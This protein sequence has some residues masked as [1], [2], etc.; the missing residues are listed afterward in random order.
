MKPPQ[1]DMRQKGLFFNQLSG[2]LNP[3][4]PI[5]MLSSKTHWEEFELKFGASFTD[6]AGRPPKPV[7]LMLGL[8]MLQHINGLSDEQV[9]SQWIENPYWQLFCGY[10][11]MQWKPP[12]DPSSLTRW[13]QRIGKDGISDILSGTV[14]TAEATGFVKKKDLSKVIAD[15]TAMEKNMRYP[16][17]SSLL[18]EARSK[19]VKEA[20]K[21]GIVLRQSYALVGKRLLQKA[22]GYAHAKQFKRC[23]KTNKKLRGILGRV[24]RDIER[25]AD[26]LQEKNKRFEQII[27]FSKRLIK[28][29]KRS[30][31]KLYSLH[32]PESYCMSKGKVR[33]PYE[34]GNKVSLV[35]SHKQGLAICAKSLSKNE[36]DGH[37]LKSSLE[38]SEKITGVAI[39]QSFVDRGYRNHGI[40][41]S[42]VYISG[43]KKNMTPS[44]KRALKRRS[45]IE[46]HIG[47][48]KTEGKLDRN[49]L[50]GN[51]GAEMN[52]ILCAVGHNLR[53]ILKHLRLFLAKI[54][55]GLINDFICYFLSRQILKIIRFC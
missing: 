33:K 8:L 7:R 12:I 6:G 37:T 1:V 15:T 23:Q 52:A 54:I 34:F 22:Q 10:E 18:N 28:Q 53:L 50:K 42:E 43:Q 24:I 2:Q 17:D 20:V 4:H 49:Y 32:A 27:E 38:T 44:L 45:A 36:Y 26:P 13:R 31:N 55:N 46:P 29:H 35:V 3:S 51:S 39:K 21:T 47:H 19:L 14:K 25:K 30:K 16:T 5:L 9:V 41:D 48:M 40:K 11:E